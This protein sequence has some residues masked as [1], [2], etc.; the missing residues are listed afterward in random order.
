MNAIILKLA[1]LRAEIQHRVTHNTM[2]ECMSCEMFGEES[3]G[4]E[5]SFRNNKD[6]AVFTIKCPVCSAEW[7]HY[8]MKK[9][10]W[11][12]EYSERAAR[13]KEKMKFNSKVESWLY[14]QS[15][16]RIIR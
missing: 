13:A 5:I 7:E 14:E 11:K 4:E 10:K 12:K 9:D 2:N 6:F 8:L 1:E 16:P 3:R 15:K